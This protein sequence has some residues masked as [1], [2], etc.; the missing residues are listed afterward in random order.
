[1]SFKLW[2]E[3]IINNQLFVNALSG[4]PQDLK[5][6]FI[7]VFSS[8]KDLRQT[9][10]DYDNKKLTQKAMQV[11]EVVSNIKLKIVNTRTEMFDRKNRVDPHDDYMEFMKSGEILLISMKL[12]SKTTYF[13]VSDGNFFHIDF[14]PMS[15]LFKITKSDPSNFLHS[16]QKHCICYL[17]AKMKHFNIFF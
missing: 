17:F 9:F 2:V 13:G 7:T 8:D 14:K 10:L 5:Y 11:D 1:M 4:N 6:Y 16:F 12:P 15:V 3:N